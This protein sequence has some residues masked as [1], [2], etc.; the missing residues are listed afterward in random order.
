MGILHNGIQGTMTG[1]LGGHVGSTKDGRN[2]IR[3]YRKNILNPRTAGQV[4]QRSRFLAC[5]MLAS[6]INSTICLPLWK[7]FA[8][9]MSGN[10]AFVSANTTAFSDGGV[11]NGVNMILSKGKMMKPVISDV[12]YT[13]NSGSWSIT[14]AAV[15][16]P[17]ALPSDKVYVLIV[18]SDI[19]EK[20]NQKIVF[21]GKT[22]FDR[23]AYEGGSCSGQ[24]A[25]DV[26]GDI[27]AFVSYLRADGSI[28]SDSAVFTL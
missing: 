3:T 13:P 15:V 18:S 21:A 16:D 28:V 26:T 6:Q 12:V 8:K 10:N 20:G 9:N 25:F 24:G 17:Y 11:F 7:R 19:D 5:T 22:D 23:S 14:G 27:W 4:A 2:T 1:K